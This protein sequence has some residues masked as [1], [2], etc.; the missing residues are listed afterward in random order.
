[1]DGHLFRLCLNLGYCEQPCNK[2]GDTDVVQLLC[3]LDGYTLVI[4]LDHM[5][6]LSLESPV[7][8]D[9]MGIQI[10]ILINSK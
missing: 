3:L 1:M 9:V 4:V 7:L 6:L 10:Y 2:H 8:F 5:V